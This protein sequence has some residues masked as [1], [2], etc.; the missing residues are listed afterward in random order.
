MPESVSLAM[1]SVLTEF[2]LTY[3]S[4]VRLY[5]D[6]NPSFNNCRFLICVDA[7]IPSST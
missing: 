6:R 4:A 2:W 7:S 5:F 3:I 1:L